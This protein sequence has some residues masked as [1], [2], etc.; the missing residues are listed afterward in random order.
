M[1]RRAVPITDGKCQ[2]RSKNDCDARGHTF[3][4]KVKIAGTVI[5]F[6]RELCEDEEN[7]LVGEASR[8]LF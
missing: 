1:K 5:A 2:K 4:L 7:M 6:S 3:R 8:R